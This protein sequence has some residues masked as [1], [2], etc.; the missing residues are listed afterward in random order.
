MAVGVKRKRFRR[1]AE[2]RRDLRRRHATPDLHRGIAVSEV[3]G[4]NCGSRQ[5]CRGAH[6]TFP[7]YGRR[8]AVEDAPLRGPVVGRA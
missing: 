7:A 3:Y 8:E 1:V 5:L 4:L 2:L 6:I